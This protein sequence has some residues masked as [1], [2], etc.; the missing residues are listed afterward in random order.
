MK[1]KGTTGAIYTR[2]IRTE[3]EC[4]GGLALAKGSSPTKVLA[5]LCL[6]TRDASKVRPRIIRIRKAR[7]SIEDIETRKEECLTGYMQL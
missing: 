4:L 1:T 7:P 5:L 3:H 6:C 2:F